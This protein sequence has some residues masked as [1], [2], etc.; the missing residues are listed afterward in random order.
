MHATLLHNCT[1]SITSNNLI[2]FEAMF[3]ESPYKLSLFVFGC[4]AYVHANG[5]GRWSRFAE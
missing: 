4:C 3:G 5:E 2:S 1:V